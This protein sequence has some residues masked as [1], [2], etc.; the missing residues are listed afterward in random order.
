M[1]TGQLAVRTSVVFRR[2]SW[3]GGTVNKPGWS[4]FASSEGLYSA[5]CALWQAGSSHTSAN[6]KVSGKSRL[7]QLTISAV[8]TKCFSWF[9]LE[10]NRLIRAGSP[11]RTAGTFRET[12]N[13]RRSP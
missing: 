8:M 12:L 11:V 1:A 2:A 6:P 4:F 3:S 13:D 9:L 5:G 10:N 7:R